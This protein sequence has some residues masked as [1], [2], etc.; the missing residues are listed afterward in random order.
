IS[1]RHKKKKGAKITPPKSV[2]EAQN[3]LPTAKP[4]QHNANHSDTV[5]IVNGRVLPRSSA[6]IK[7]DKTPKN[8]SSQ[9]VNNANKDS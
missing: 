8:N 4:V 1:R 2:V 7:R 9:S 3:K 5:R 6:E